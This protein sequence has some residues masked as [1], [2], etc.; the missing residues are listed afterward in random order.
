MARIGRPSKLTPETLEA[1]EQGIQAQLPYKLACE[2]AGIGY[3]TYREWMVAAEKIREGTY[4][5]SLKTELLEFS[6]RM[7]KAEAEG[8]KRLITLIWRRHR[9]IVASRT[10]DLREAPQ[11]GV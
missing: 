7:K 5:G 4:E 8:A 2:A 9:R 1:L 3:S 10:C 6:D 11:E